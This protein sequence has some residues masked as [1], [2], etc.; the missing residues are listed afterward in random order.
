M[1]KSG[2]PEVDE[3][4]EGGVGDRQERVHPGHDAACPSVLQESNDFSN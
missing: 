2:I 1:R 4:V 3:K